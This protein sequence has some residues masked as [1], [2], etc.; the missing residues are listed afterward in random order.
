MAVYCK[1]C[2]NFD[3]GE[4]SKDSF[5]PPTWNKE[6][7]NAPENF[8]KTH[9]RSS[10]HRISTPKVINRRGNCTWY[11]PLFTSSSSSGSGPLP[12]QPEDSSSSSSFVMASSS[13]S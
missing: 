9:K 1:E 13:S 2:F 12:P 5:G 4:T 6:F 3:D 11:V 7:C 8:R 10:Q